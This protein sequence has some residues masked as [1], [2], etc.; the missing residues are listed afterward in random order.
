[1]TRFLLGFVLAV[2]S[3][4]AQNALHFDLTGEW[5]SQ[6]GDDLAWSRPDFDDSGWPSVPLPRRG[7]P[8]EGMSWL[9]GHFI[10][11][12]G[13]DRM[14][15]AL[16]LGTF[17][18]AY[19]V[20]CNGVRAGSTGSL[21]PDQS[22]TARPRTFTLRAGLIIPGQPLV[23]ALRRNHSGARPF[24]HQLEALPDE[25]PY[26]LTDTASAPRDATTVSLLRRQRLVALGFVSSALRALL[27]AMLLAAW[28]TATRRRDLLLLALLLGADF[29]VRFL[30]SWYVV[31][32]PQVGYT[33]GVLLV[34]ASASS[35]LAWFA[36]EVFRIRARWPYFVLWLP[37]AIFAVLWRWMITGYSMALCHVAVFLLALWSARKAAVAGGWRSAPVAM[38][39]SIAAVTALQSQRYGPLAFINLYR[40]SGG[41]LFHLYDVFVIILVAGMTVHLLL[42]LGADR[43]EKER[44]TSEMEAARTVQQLLLAPP[45]ATSGHQ[46][47]AVYLPAA[48]VGGDFYWTRVESDGALLLAVGDVSGKGLKA[49]MLVSV[50]IG[51]LRRET[52]LSPAAVLAGLN[53]SLFGHTGGGFVTCCCARFDTDG[54]VT[55]ANA[56]HPSPY[57]DGREVAVEAGL[58]LGVLA[59][60]E[61]G[62]SAVSGDAFTFVSDGVVEAENAQRELFGF[63]RTRDISGKSAQEI[64]E[65][66]KAWGQNDDIT[67][68]TVRR[69]V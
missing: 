30:E 55:I 63:D 12:P 31:T 65:A 57:S 15:L 34:V 69:N 32:D 28:F 2:A 66:A 68:V 39:L 5:R 43:R 40:E 19:E 52:S 21:S 49:A 10:A 27:F 48:Q 11:P 9:R 36:C 29:I 59:G 42:S 50:T 3:A 64:A 13:A 14:P 44:L 58:P 7:L 33:D 22:G 47:E 23:I 62:E 46:T 54:R 24:P 16:T 17:A 53:G 51:T 41:Y 61:Y 35:L 8:P 18:D 37:P 1:M 20:W 26:V 25:G 67:V 60:V 56:G 45:P 6:A 38:A 4:S